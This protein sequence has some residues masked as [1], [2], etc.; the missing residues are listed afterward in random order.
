MPIE[1]NPGG[2]TI[3]GNA[4]NW[5]QVRVVRDGM[6]FY[7]RQGMKL[8]RMYTPA[9]P[10]RAAHHRRRAAHERT[11]LEADRLVSRQPWTQPNALGG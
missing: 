1:S 4:I 2:I 8:N 11:Y 9:S 5:F 3:T 7:L 6:A 10:K